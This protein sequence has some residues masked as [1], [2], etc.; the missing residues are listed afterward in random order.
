MKIRL[1]ARGPDKT[2]NNIN[3]TISHTCA[4]MG[5]QPAKRGPQAIIYQEMSVVRRPLFIKNLS[6]F[7]TLD[8][9]NTLP[10]VASARAVCTTN[11]T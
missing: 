9:A 1:H 6:G 7:L 4:D 11:I 10:Y 5:Y 8:K 2:L 3:D